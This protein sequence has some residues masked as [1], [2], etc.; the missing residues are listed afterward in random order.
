MRLITWNCFRG[1]AL[2]RAADLDDLAPDIV[3]LQECSRPASAESERFAWSGQNPRHG[4]A[5]IANGAYTLRPPAID[6][7][8]TSSVFATQV[9]GPRALRCSPSGRIGG[10]TT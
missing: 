9:V 1:D 3:V 8:P 2:T 5:V 6:I 10:P 7:D 4:M